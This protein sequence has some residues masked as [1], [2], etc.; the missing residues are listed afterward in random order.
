MVTLDVV[1]D[2]AADQEQLDT[3]RAAGPN[4]VVV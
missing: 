1:T 4:L 2:S 3:L